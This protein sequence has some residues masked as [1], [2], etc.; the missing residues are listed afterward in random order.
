MF[1]NKVMLLIVMECDDS[2]DIYSGN[3]TMTVIKL[4]GTLKRYL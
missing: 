3:K 2:I 4:K 1:N